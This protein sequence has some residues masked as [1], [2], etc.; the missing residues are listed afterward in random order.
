MMIQS[1]IEA[2]IGQDRRNSWPRYALLILCLAQFGVVLAYQGTTISLPEVE[3]SFNLS[4]STSQWLV[5]INALTYG[6]LLL[7]AGRAA[8]LFGHRR[9]FVLG[10]ALFGGASLLAGLAPTVEWLLVARALQGVGTACFTPAMIALLADMYPEGPERNRALAFWGASG[11]LGGVCA[12]LMGG[13]LASALGWRAVFL[14]GAPISLIVVL[15]ALAVLPATQRRVSA[16]FDPFGAMIGMIGIAAMIQGLA[17]LSQSQ[18]TFSARAIGWVVG[19]AVVLGLFI[20]RERRSASPLVPALLRGRWPIWR[21][22]CVAVCHG[23]AT[24]TPIVFYS[25][26]MQHYRAAS[27]W[28]I[29]IGFLPCNL[30]SSPRPRL[31]H[32]LLDRSGS[33]R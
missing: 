4:V 31:L 28:E 2:T 13:A 10:S 21:P 24:N 20:R 25:L 11:P 3:R 6:G 16:R 19:G 14:I 27:P 12:I 1:S 7:P 5:S 17:T 9:I 15:V 32:V 8:D 33:G 22:I 29:G 26:Y 18:S 30:N 23:A